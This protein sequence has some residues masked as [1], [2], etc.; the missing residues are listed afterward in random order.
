VYQRIGHKYVL[1]WPSTILGCVSFFITIPIYIFYWKGPA[2]RARS[3]F[4]LT[5]A[6]GRKARASERD[7]GEKSWADPNPSADV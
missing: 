2:I 3:P 7:T 6:S 4:A 1:E 5:L